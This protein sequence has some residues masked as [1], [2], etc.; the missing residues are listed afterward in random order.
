[1]TEA[2]LREELARL[3]RVIPQQ[4][5]ELDRMRERRDVLMQLF[6]EKFAAAARVVPKPAAIGA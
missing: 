1:M 6:P 2:E 5:A 4:A 3:N